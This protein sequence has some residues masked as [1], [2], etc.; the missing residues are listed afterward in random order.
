MACLYINQQNPWMHDTPD[1]LCTCDCGGEGF[2]EI[3]SPPCIENCYFDL[4]VLKP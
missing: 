3:K 2:G 4:Y 1:F